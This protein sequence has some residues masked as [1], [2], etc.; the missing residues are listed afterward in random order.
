MS[1]TEGLEEITQLTQFEASLQ[2]D[3]GGQ[4]VLA[5]LAELEIAERAATTLMERQDTANHGDFVHFSRG[6][7]AAQR[8][9][10]QFWENT[11]GRLQNAWSYS[12]PVS[13]LEPVMGPESELSPLY[14]IMTMTGLLAHMS[15]YDEAELGLLDTFIEEAMPSTVFTYRV[16]CAL[17]LGLK[18][19]A[20]KAKERLQQRIDENPA[21]E[22]AKITLGAALA[23]SGDKQWRDSLDYVAA[24]SENQSYREMV[25]SMISRAEAAGM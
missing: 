3:L 10:R 9:L 24:T 4:M 19:G 11:H 7:A 15:E 5:L 22:L 14:Q 20:E 16:Y 13:H 23:L 25:T 17:A 18:G 2:N 21:D 6:F 8:V 12:M 1:Q